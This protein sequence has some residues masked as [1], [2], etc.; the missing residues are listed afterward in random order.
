MDNEWNSSHF[1]MKARNANWSYISNKAKQIF[2]SS[3]LLQIVQSYDISW[4]KMSHCKVWTIRTSRVYKFLTN[5]NR[6]KL[7]DAQVHVLTV[8]I[9]L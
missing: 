4:P 2:S 7:H 5:N 6:H 3:Q 1:D 9:L 8:S